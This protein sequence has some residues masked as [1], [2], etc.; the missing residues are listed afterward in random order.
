MAFSRPIGLP[1]RP[2]ASQLTAEMA[3]IGLRFAVSPS[4][5]PDIEDTL[6]FASEL[7]MLDHD[8][9]T[10]SLL[11][12]WLGVHL[13]YVNIERLLRALDGYPA[14]RVL[15]Y[16]SA[17][18]AWQRRD[19]RL[20]RLER[21]YTEEPVALLAVGTEFQI[22]RRGEDKRFLGTALRAPDGTLRD[23]LADIASPADL[24]RTHTTYRARVVIGPTW[25]ADAWA[26][27]EKNPHWTPSQVA[28]EARCAF[29][30]AW[31]VK[32]DFTLVRVT[33]SNRTVS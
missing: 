31:H 27:L 11:T 29:A 23:R 16:W 22:R 2:T 13:A 17:I 5:D 33:H 1:D 20:R 25:R 3:G 28:N 15:A 18:G 6:V 26:A 21:L 9:R 19:R 12:T 24:A 14:P 4:E 7:G 8:L 30:T 32:R 10:L